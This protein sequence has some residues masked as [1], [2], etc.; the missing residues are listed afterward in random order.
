[1]ERDKKSLFQFSLVS[2]NL[3]SEVSQEK[4]PSQKVKDKD[5]NV[6]CSF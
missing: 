3:V 1:M 6:T 4:L 5:I 2:C